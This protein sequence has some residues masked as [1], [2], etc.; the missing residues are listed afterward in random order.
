MR[1]LIERIG[2]V[3]IWEEEDGTYTVTD[4]KGTVKYFIED[5]DEAR[6]EAISWLE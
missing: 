3:E 5:A 4:N 2:D 1:N 6:T